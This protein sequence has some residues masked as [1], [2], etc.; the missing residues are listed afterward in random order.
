VI[1]MKRQREKRWEK[2]KRKEEEKR[3]VLKVE[4]IATAVQYGTAQCSTV[5]YSTVQYSTVQF[6]TV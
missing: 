5:Q 1:K 3:G 6:S 4:D 2:G